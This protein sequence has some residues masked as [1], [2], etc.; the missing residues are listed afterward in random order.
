MLIGL[1][2]MIVAFWWV[3]SAVLV[4]YW[5]VGRLFCGLAFAGNLVYGEKVRGLFSMSRSYWFMFNLL[6]IGPFLFCAFFGMNALFSSDPR[7]FIVREPLSG[8]GIKQ[9]WVEHG[10]L[11]P[12]VIA[13]PGSTIVLTGTMDPGKR[14]FSVLRLSKGLLGFDVMG[15]REPTYVPSGQ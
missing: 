6:A 15:W 11:P 8:L 12:I 3:A 14:E 2:S 5:V 1:F 9:H 7:T 4:S 13:A 10:L